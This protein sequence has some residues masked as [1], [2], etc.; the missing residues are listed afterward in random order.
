MMTDTQIIARLENSGFHEIRIV[1]DTISM[2]DPTCILRGFESFIQIAGT[3]CGIVAFLL[4][5]AW[6][7]SLI[8][9]TK[10]S[11]T[12]SNFKN[13]T[14]IF[15]TLAIVGFAVNFVIG[16]N[17]WKI[18]CDRLEVSRTQVN[19]ILDARDQRLKEQDQIWEHFEIHDSA[20]SEQF[21]RESQEAFGADNAIH[22]MGIMNWA[23]QQA[24]QASNNARRVG[25]YDGTVFGGTCTPPAPS[26]V[27]GSRD[28]TTGQY[29]AVD[30]VFQKALNATFRAEGGYVNN[31]YDHGGETKYGVSA[32]ANPN[33]D[34][35]NLTRADAERIAYNNYYKKY[36]IDKL[37][38]GIRGEVFQFGWGAGPRVAI[39]KLQENL[40]V[41]KT[42]AVD[43]TTIAAARGY[44]GDLP[45][46]YVDK[47]KAYTDAIV[48]R[49]PTQRIFHRGWNNRIDLIR[50]N[51]CN[52]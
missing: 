28:Y 29:A 8:R 14:I 37:P 36:G 51:G 35:K 2:Q 47:Y 6:A 52:S 27:F 13:L 41:P 3:V 21:Y 11:E 7:I 40:G 39:K 17:L 9:G 49:D 38:D 34:I 26:R 23:T 24:Q 31:K 12:V 30:L 43:A 10:I 25:H 18:G 46:E 15:G 1:G 4:I 50:A 42:G 19:E 44:A 5:F 22:G 48:A 32:A 45:N 20:G 16:E 33:V